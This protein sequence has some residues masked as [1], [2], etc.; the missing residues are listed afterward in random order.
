M[1]GVPIFQ[2]LALVLCILISLTL[3]LPSTS[4]QTPQSGVLNFSF[5]PTQFS[6]PPLPAG[7]NLPPLPNGFTF[8][9]TPPVL[10][11]PTAPTGGLTSGIPLQTTTTTSTSTSSPDSPIASA[12]SPPGFFSEIGPVLSQFEP[13]ASLPGGSA[14]I[15]V[16]TSAPTSTP[17]SAPTDAPTDA[18]I[19]APTSAPTSPVD[20]ETQ[21]VAAPGSGALAPSPTTLESI[22]VSSKIQNFQ[23]S[24]K[25]HTVNY[26]K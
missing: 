16:P 26:A 3:K 5:P 6:I 15:G 9:G 10:P 24:L 19:S 22:A 25:N 23:S 20:Y 11:D 7:V 17:T 18:P 2:I 8:S 14:R 12:M 13:G 21:P 4:A 1:K